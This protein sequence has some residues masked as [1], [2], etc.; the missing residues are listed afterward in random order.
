MGKMDIYVVNIL[1]KK[2]AGETPCKQSGSLSDMHMTTC[3]WAHN[4]T[5]TKSAFQTGEQGVG[6]TFDKVLHVI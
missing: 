6:R 3:N 5:Q 1:E 4:Y 2:S